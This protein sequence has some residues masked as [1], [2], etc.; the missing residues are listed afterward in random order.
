MRLQQLKSLIDNEVNSD[1]LLQILVPFNSIDSTIENNRKGILYWKEFSNWQQAMDD[2]RK[3]LRSYSMG[4]ISITKNRR[5]SIYSK[6][7]SKY[8]KNWDVETYANSFTLT[9]K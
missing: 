2:H 8:F 3:A 6:M 5:F 1:N 4:G 9:R 7:M